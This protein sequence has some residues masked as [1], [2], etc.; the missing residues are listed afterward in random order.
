L[1]YYKL[2]STLRGLTTKEEL[3]VML[4][5]LKAEVKQEFILK[6]E[7]YSN[8]LQGKTEDRSLGNFNSPQLNHQFSMKNTRSTLNRSNS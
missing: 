5:N 6:E 7:N 8:Y 2:D 3:T 4:N 1:V